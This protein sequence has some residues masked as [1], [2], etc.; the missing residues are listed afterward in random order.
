MQKS[1]K[2]ILVVSQYYKPEP[3]RIDDICT[4]LVKRGYQVTVLTGIPNYPEGKF[5]PGYGWT[6]RRKETIDGV[7]VIRIPLIPRGKSFVGLALNY[8]SFVVTGF[9]WQLFTKVKAD[10]VFGFGLSPIFQAL[11]G[12]W[13][14]RQKKIP[15]YLYVQDLWPESLEMVLGVRNK[16][17]LG[18]LGKLVAYIYKNC[19]I[20]LGTS[21]AYVKAICQRVP[22]APEKVR[23]WPQYAEAF[24]VPMEKKPIPEI[25]DDGSFKVVYTGNLGQTQGLDILAPT[26]KLLKQQSVDNVRFVIIGNGRYR[27]RLVA[28]IE[29]AGVADMFTLIDRQPAQRIPEMLAACDVAFISFSDNPLYEKTIPAK[30][31]SYLACGMPIVA[32]VKGE[33]ERIIIEAGCGSCC[34]MGDA[35]ALAKSI[36]GVMEPATLKAQAA[37]ARIYFEAH[38]EKQ[39]LMDQLETMLF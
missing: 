22:D 6:G 29:N 27:E 5:Y 11:I 3:F 25:P 17:L 16:M 2:H 26:A 10:A 9:F 21:P 39:K 4:E 28:E 36:I 32:A 20:I 13:Y 34:P 38:F 35:A 19:S 24:Y 1:K 37:G 30:L 7:D 15:M 18:A 31:Q 8:M 23:C 14:A 33:T 12:V